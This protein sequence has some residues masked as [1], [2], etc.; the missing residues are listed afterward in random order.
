MGKSLLIVYH[1]QSGATAR[2]AGAAAEGAGR[3]AELE[4]LLRRVW[5]SG[6][7]E[8]LACDGLL[9][10]FA[11]NSGALAGAMKD[12]LDRV[13]YPLQ[14]C[15]QRKPLGI[16]VSAGN[17]G[18]GALAQARRI[19]RGLPLDEVAEPL[20]CLGEPDAAALERCAELGQTLA[21]GMGL[22]IF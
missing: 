11:E 9:L 3:E 2:L 18:R 19:I 17:D 15:R 16:I 13:F 6:S 5:D 12:Y 22:G 4:T 1:S 7:R 20:I 21:A 8:L 14:G 10:A